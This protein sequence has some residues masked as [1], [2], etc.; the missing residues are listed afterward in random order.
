VQKKALTKALKP[1]FI[2][3]VKKKTGIKDRDQATQIE[4]SLIL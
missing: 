4:T 1:E 2:K 3:Y